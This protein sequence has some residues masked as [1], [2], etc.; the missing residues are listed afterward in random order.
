M[1]DTLYDGDRAIIDL[2]DTDVSQGGI[3]AV[4]DDLGTLII[5]QVE[6]VR[7][8]G[9]GARRILCSSRNSAYQPFELKLEDP[10]KIIGRVAC[11]ITRI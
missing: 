5:K 4:L 2:D 9:K 3:F 10:V 8:G 11:K 7:S 1:V 6:M